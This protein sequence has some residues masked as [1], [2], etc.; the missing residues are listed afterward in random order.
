MNISYFLGSNS[1]RGFYSLYGAF[2][3]DGSGVMHIIKG[4]PGS[5][6]SGFMRKIAAAASERGIDTECI[7]CSGDPESLDSIYL[8]SLHIGWVDGTAPHAAEPAAFGVDS[9]YVNLGQFCSLPLRETD[10]A[11]ILALSMEY[12]ALYRRAY[13]YLS[14]AESLRSNCL[15]PVFSADQLE[16]V[17]KRVCGI[18]DRELGRAKGR[19]GTERKR[20]ISALTCKGK[21][22]LSDSM[23]KLCK[24][25]YQFDN[26]YHGAGALLETVRREALRRGEEIIYCPDPLCPGEAEAVLIPGRS[27]AFTTDAWE[28][29]NARHIR[30]NSV[31]SADIQRR[32]RREL[33]SSLQ[34]EQGAVALALEKLSQAKALHDEL[35]LIYRPYM[36][37]AALDEFTAGVIARTF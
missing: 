18:L 4:G 37:F 2:P 15:P 28:F 31:L 34:L 17:S 19:C 11:K 30:L 32:C 25:I 16:R 6:K 29:E 3:G 10:S 27:L 1:G 14:A 20:F 5:G 12:K 35:E 13:G 23:S 26:S 22:A 21:V 8:P 9:D 24:L 33:R 36:D 7:L